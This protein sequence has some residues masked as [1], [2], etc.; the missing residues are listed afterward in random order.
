MSN[1]FKGD[2]MWGDFKG[3]ALGGLIMGLGKL[4]FVCLQLTLVG[5]LIYG[6][7]KATVCVIRKVFFGKELPDFEEFPKTWYFFAVIFWLLVFYIGA[8]V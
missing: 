5:L 2:T 6:C 7:L 8:H 1:E 3:T 4:L